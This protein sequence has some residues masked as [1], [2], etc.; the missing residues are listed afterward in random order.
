M[1]PNFKTYLKE[2]VWM[3]IH[4][5]SVGDTERREDNA[6]NLMKTDEFMKYL[7]EYYECNHGIITH[8]GPPL[9]EIAVQVLKPANS[10][11]F[12][13]YVSI[14][15]K[16]GEDA[17]VTL[18]C[19]LFVYR[20][21][22]NGDDY[23]KKTLLDNFNVKLTTNEPDIARERYVRIYPKDDKPVNNLF[24]ID[25]LNTILS[26]A[27]RN[28]KKGLKQKLAE[29]VWMDIHKQSN[30][31]MER[32]EDD[33]NH[34]DAKGLIAYLKDTYTNLVPE[35]GF[36]IN[37]NDS[38]YYPEV[39]VPVYYNSTNSV[40]AMWVYLQMYSSGC[41]VFLGQRFAN[42]CRTVYEKMKK[43]FEVDMVDEDNGRWHISVKPKDGSEA[44]NKFYIQVIDFL[45]ANVEEPYKVI[46]EKK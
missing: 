31:D 28:F 35:K 3:D 42:R 38:K 25:V 30:G 16:L 33:V 27:G 4:K 20:D 36:Y 22:D 29:S 40:E 14:Y 37:G 9:D 12:Y 13:V 1:I 10:Y 15:N 26:A 44:T 17:Y 18:P 7:H 2:S 34:M 5:Q 45:L 8:I 11:G 21:S 32:M 24:F 46:L 43:E 41:Y 39:H 6:V 19:R 23:L